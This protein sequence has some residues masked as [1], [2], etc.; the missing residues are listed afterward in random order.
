MEQ[1]STNTKRE[2]KAEEWLSLISRVEEQAKRFD[3]DLPKGKQ[4]AVARVLAKKNKHAAAHL[5][6]IAR[7]TGGVTRRQK[8]GLEEAQKWAHSLENSAQEFEAI[9]ERYRDGSEVSTEDGVSKAF[10]SASETLLDMHKIADALYT[11]RE[12]DLGHRKLCGLWEL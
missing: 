9:A 8:R 5:L 11:A 7:D 2:L 4:A 12:R 6:S 1:G 3:V 10:R